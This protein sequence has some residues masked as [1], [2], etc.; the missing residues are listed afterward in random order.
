MST[1]GNERRKSRLTPH[2]AQKG[3][4]GAISEC[5]PTLELDESG[6]NRHNVKQPQG[7]LPSDSLSDQH[8]A[9]LCDLGEGRVVSGKHKRILDDLVA[10]GFLQSASDETV[11]YKLTGK[12]QNLLAQ[13][14]AGLNEA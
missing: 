7:R 13:R 11:G 8:I 3:G 4:Q 2:D 14:G 6:G 5:D 10:D 12:A 9:I 1:T